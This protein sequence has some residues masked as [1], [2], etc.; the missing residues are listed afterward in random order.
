MG[1]VL[2]ITS[3][4]MAG[5]SLAQA[6]L[7]GAI[8]VWHDILYDGPREPGWP[9][10]E[11]FHARALFLEELTAGGLGREQILET[12]RDQYQQLATAGSY[13]RI[14]LWFDACL[15]DQSMLVHVLTCLAQ[16]GLCQ[17]DLLCIDK[18]PGIEPFHGLG[19]LRPEQL[20]SL[21]P[22]RRPVSAEQFAFAAAVDRAFAQQ[23]NALFRDLSTM[24]A[25][26]LPW[27]PAAVRR[28][29][30]EQPDPATGLG[31]LETLALAAIRSGCTTPGEI[32]A[33]VAAADG[34][35]QYWG[36]ITLWGKLNGLADRFPPLVTISGPLA[37][38]P[39]WESPVPLSEFSISVC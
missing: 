4:D 27:V 15:F 38:L 34:P 11:T 31:R 30:Q 18:F 7:T 14:V 33:A 12:L 13:E 32:F 5:A 21:Y 37:R 39:Q 19:Q 28:W 26:P 3:G 2:H 17:V 29:L 1:K 16:Q 25:A 9:D 35:P 22:D 10:E 23:D 8:L 36:D 20:A 24:S 6:G